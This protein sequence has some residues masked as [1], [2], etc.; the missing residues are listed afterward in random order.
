MAIG[1]GKGRPHPLGRIPA[2]VIHLGLRLTHNLDRRTGK[3]IEV[4]AACGETVAL[5]RKPSPESPDFGL[6]HF[7]KSCRRLVGKGVRYR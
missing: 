4:V 1:H 3:L 6:E 7:L 5:S 2:A